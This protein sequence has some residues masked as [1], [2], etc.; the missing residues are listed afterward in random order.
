MDSSLKVC[1][2]GAAGNIAYAFI[3]LLLTGQVFGDRQIELRLLDIPQCENV[4]KGVIMEIHDSVYT[5]LTSVSSGS[6]PNLMFK[7][8][9][10]IVFLGGFPRKPGM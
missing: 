2:T 3:P 4:L 10:V 6:D 1:I 5:R 8:A 9:D 7:D